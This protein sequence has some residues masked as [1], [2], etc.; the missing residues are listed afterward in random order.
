MPIES[1]PS[2]A[3]EPPT[4]PRRPWL[5]SVAAITTIAMVL[6]GCGGSL[7]QDS[8][9]E[10]PS[11]TI[12]QD[13]MNER[14][15]AAVLQDVRIENSGPAVVTAEMVT[16]NIEEAAAE[17]IENDPDLAAAEAGLV[18]T[19]AVFK[20]L[21]AAKRNDATPIPEPGIRGLWSCTLDQ[22]VTIYHPNPS[23]HH[24]VATVMR[25]K[26]N[27][28]TNSSWQGVMRGQY[29]TQLA[30]S[31]GS[32][33]ASYLTTNTLVKN[34]IR[35]DGQSSST[36][37]R[38][39]H[40]LQFN[41]FDR[42]LC[43]DASENILQGLNGPL[44]PFWAKVLASGVTVVTFGLTQVILIAAIP[45]M[46]LLEPGAWDISACLAAFTSVV[47]YEAAVRGG[48]INQLTFVTALG[49]CLLAVLPA[50]A[51][52]GKFASTYSPM[53]KGSAE[54]LRNGAFKLWGMGRSAASYLE[55]CIQAIITYDSRLPD[56]GPP[57]RT[58]PSKSDGDVQLKPL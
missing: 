20:I 46:A 44:S 12:S 37:S 33:T 42:H 43:R 23:V 35:Y 54:A 22:V 28:F 40:I 6:Q 1:N 52:R 41:T 30:S 7:A 10:S 57:V 45:E 5:R 51:F 32:T 26:G 16:S 53:I 15:I 55:G 2:T 4:T 38:F 50:Y 27:I 19:G 29:N 31:V 14:A 47:V 8:D 18:A 17:A 34:D 36:Q 39:R 9:P 13:V 21:S 56:G 49:A 11:S 3:S 24:K 48:S 25:K 58:K